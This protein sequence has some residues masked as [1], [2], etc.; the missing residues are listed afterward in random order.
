MYTLGSVVLG[1]RGEVCFE[2]GEVVYLSDVLT[3]QKRAHKVA[4]VDPLE[5]RRYQTE[6]LKKYS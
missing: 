6:S 1:T 5:I 3:P 2:E 4:K